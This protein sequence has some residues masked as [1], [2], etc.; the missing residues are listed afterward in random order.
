MADLEAYRT[1]IEGLREQALSCKVREIILV[2]SANMFSFN[3]RIH[4]IIPME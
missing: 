1:N 3:F 4:E 2:R